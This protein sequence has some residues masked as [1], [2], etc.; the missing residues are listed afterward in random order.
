MNVP[1]GERILPKRTFALA[2]KRKTPPTV[3]NQPN[4]GGFLKK[5]QMKII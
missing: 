1:Y 4:V 2:G 5:K 3:S